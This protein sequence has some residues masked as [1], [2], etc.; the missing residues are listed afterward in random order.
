MK[1]IFFLVFLLISFCSFG[2]I[3]KVGISNFYQDSLRVLVHDII[4]NPVINLFESNDEK[5]ISYDLTFNI[6]GIIYEWRRLENDTLDNKKIEQL[7]AVKNNMPK[8]NQLFIE[9]VK[10]VDSLGL[11]QEAR[12]LY[13]WLGK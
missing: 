13:L 4:Q 10:Y 6:N 7:L 9:K 12:G 3:R 5:I 2:Q 1:R 8:Y 11:E